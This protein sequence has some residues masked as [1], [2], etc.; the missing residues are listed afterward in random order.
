M[1]V[2]GGGWVERGSLQGGK[3]GLEGGR[4]T[5]DRIRTRPSKLAGAKTDY[6]RSSLARLTVE[7]ILIVSTWRGS[8]DV[9]PMNNSRKRSGDTLPLSI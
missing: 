5:S 9:E 3:G 2:R 8:R 7:N 1:V 6:Y 4:N